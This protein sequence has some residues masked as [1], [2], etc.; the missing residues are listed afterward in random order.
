MSY[1]ESAFCFDCLGDQLVGITAEPERNASEASELG[2]LIVVGGPQY[3]VGSHRQFVLLSRDLAEK[4]IPCM[5]FDFRGMGDSTGKQR[6]FDDVSA[7][8]KS[9]VDCFFARV[10]GIKRVV[11]WGLCDGASA[12]C[13]YAPQDGRVAGLVMLNPWVRTGALEARTKLRH[14]YLK[15]LFDLNFW[16]KLLSG[17]VRLSTTVNDLAKTADALQ[18][19]GPDAHSLPQKMA[20]ALA[21][22]GVPFA[23]FLSQRDYVARE[24]ED[25]VSREARWQALMHGESM[26]ACERF[27]A[28]HTFSSAAARGDV[29]KMTLNIVRDIDVR[30]RRLNESGSKVTYGM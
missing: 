10:P 16:R 20:K 3:R 2:V 18:K 25:V 9:A 23:V 19:A 24:F 30:Y 6:S 8:I 17:G 12:A 26:L 21:D 28:D 27:D 1:S 29:A 11:L 5:R 14:Y 13:F 4:G 15:R 7:D 22:A